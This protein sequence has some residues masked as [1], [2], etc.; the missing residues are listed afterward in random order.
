[1]SRIIGIDLGTTYS[2]VS[3]FD[4]RQGKFV[5]VPGRSG[6]QTTPSVV[7]VTRDG[8]VVVGASAKARMAAEPES[9]IAEIKRHMGE[10]QRD[11]TG[12]ELLGADGKPVPYSVRFA[13]REHTPEMVSAYILRELKEVAETYLGEPVAS[14]VITVP[15]YFKGGA[16]RAT[17]D[18]GALAG[19]KVACLVSE[20]TAAAIAFGMT[21][22]RDDEDE[23]ER[24][25]RILVYDLGGGTFDVSVIEISRGNI[26]VKGVGGDHQLGGVDFD[27]AIVDWALR[28]IQEEHGVDLRKTDGLEPSVGESWSEGLARIASEAEKVKVALSAQQTASLTLPF[29][30]LHPGQGKMVSVDYALGRSEFLTMI[31]PKLKAT[32]ATVDRTLA[33]VKLGRGDI[34]DVLLVGGSTRIPKVQELLERHFG[35]A[36]RRDINP[37]ECVALGAAMQALRY[38]DVSHLGQ[39]REQRVEEQLGQMGQVIDVTGHSLGVREGQDNLSVLIRKNTPIPA[40]EEKVYQ[41]AGD[42]QTQIKVLVFQGE[43][44]QASRNTLLTEFDVTGLPPLPA[45][46]VKVKIRFSLDVNGILRVDVTDLVSKKQHTA[47][48]RYGGAT[49]KKPADLLPQ[50]SGGAPRGAGK[51]TSGPAVPPGMQETWKKAQELLAT[52]PAA[53]RARLEGALAEYSA[54]L[55]AGDPKRAEEKANDLMD[56]LFDVMP[57]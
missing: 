12:R 46:Q 22:R 33:D 29:L 40:V 52:L 15:A 24:P 28:K 5:I 18:A 1:M 36:P 21:A 23:E 57:I 54:A 26:E 42:Y 39:E 50:E 32:L 43:E 7:G 25:R 56:V 11:G 6:A 30:F 31:A 14:A 51:P 49:T 19:L 37:D 48:V 13:G 34:D 47:E 17:E 27:R 16:R 53:D 44:A 20:P 35:K 55:E 8:Q 4:D 38:V 41:T 45:G 10:P 9:A 2:C 3:V